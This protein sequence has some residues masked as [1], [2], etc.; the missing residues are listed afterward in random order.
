[1]MIERWLV[2]GSPELSG[3]ELPV[4]GEELA[5]AQAACCISKGSPFESSGPEQ[6]SCSFKVG[7]RGHM[8]H[9][10]LARLQTRQRELVAREVDAQMGVDPGLKFPGGLNGF[11]SV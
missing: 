11:G 7:E 8:H 10:V 1:M 6:M 4:A 5:R 9:A 2:S 3:Q